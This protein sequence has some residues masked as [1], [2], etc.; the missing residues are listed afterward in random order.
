MRAE[1]VVQRG[2]VGALDAGLNV[3]VR[4]VALRTNGGA[5][6]GGAAAHE[7]PGEPRRGGAFDPLVG[8]VFHDQV[9]VGQEHAVVGCGLLV[10]ET[11]GGTVDAGPT[12]L[13]SDV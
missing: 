8:E 13:E 6:R 2:E 12:V 9:R 7:A 5:Q 4:T 10:D 1:P 3:K 11:D